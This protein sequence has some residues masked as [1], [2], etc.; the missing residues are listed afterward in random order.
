M[1]QVKKETI[2]IFVKTL[3]GKTITLDLAPNASIEDVK[4]GV[5]LLEGIPADQQRMIY[6]GCQLEDGKTLTDYNIMKES[7]L[8]LV[9]RLR[10]QG[11]PSCKICLTSIQAAHYTSFLRDTISSGVNSFIAEFR[12]NSEC[13]ELPKITHP[14]DFFTVIRNNAPLDGTVHINIQA[15]VMQ[16]LFIPSSILRP[17]DIIHVEL[18]PR[19]IS[20]QDPN[21]DHPLGYTPDFNV[22]SCEED[23]IV[24]SASSIILNINVLSSSGIKI[25]NYCSVLQ[26]S[27]HEWFEELKRLIEKDSQGIFTID[28]I[29]SIQKQKKLANVTIHTAITNEMDVAKQLVNHDN[30]FITLNSN[31]TIRE[32]K[33]S[34]K[35]KIENE[36]EEEEVDDDHLFSDEEEEEEEEEQV[37]EPNLKLQKLTKPIIKQEKQNEQQEEEEDESLEEKNIHM[38]PGGAGIQ[39]DNNNNNSKTNQTNKN[40]SKGGVKIPHRRRKRAHKY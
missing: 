39:D 1:S 2:E 9:L 11:H 35:A 6:A 3:T 20:N 40:Q 36:E 33:K 10:G 28:H 38:P 25:L 13:K 27:S 31:I 12:K 15:N 30:I 23:F 37:K 24:A 34:E 5:R 19:A 21:P 7:T 29:Q 22:S 26:R 4:E 8:H 16:V 17:N 14:N 18:N 32:E